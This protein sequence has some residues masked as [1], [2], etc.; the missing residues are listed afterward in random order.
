MCCI[1]MQGSILGV[2]MSLCYFQESKFSRLEKKV[3]QVSG[4]FYLEQAIECRPFFEYTFDEPL[5]PVINFIL[6]ALM[7]SA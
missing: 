6:R 1:Y 3:I 2:F 7:L 4:T 5:M